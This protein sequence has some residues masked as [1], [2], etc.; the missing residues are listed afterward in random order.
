MT[1]L[2]FWSNIK[3]LSIKLFMEW[4]KKSFPLEGDSLFNLSTRINKSCL[5]RCFVLECLLGAFI[6]Q[7]L[8]K[9]SEFDLGR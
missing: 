2:Y 6:I 5:S 9:V 8:A 3:H 1:I 7:F 4:N